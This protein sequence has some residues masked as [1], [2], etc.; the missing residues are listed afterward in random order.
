MSL[1]LEITH[2]SPIGEILR[3][4]V[5]LSGDWSYL[6]SGRPF[7]PAATI[8]K[9]ELPE[10]LLHQAA[11]L[12]MAFDYAARFRIAKALGRSVKSAVLKN[13]V[14]DQAVQVTETDSF[15][16]L[17]ADQV[18]GIL[19]DAKEDVHD[20]LRGKAPLEKMLK[21]ACVLALFEGVAR[22]GR[23]FFSNDETIPLAIVIPAGMIEELERLL[24]LFEQAFMPLVHPDSVVVFNPGYAAPAPIGGSDADLYLDGTLY[25]FKVVSNFKAWAIEKEQILGYYYL[26]RLAK[27]DKAGVLNTLGDRP[28]TR[29]AFYQ[30]RLGEVV[31]HDVQGDE[32]FAQGYLEL[33]EVL[34]KK[35]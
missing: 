30:A 33:E 11:T 6:S 16:T 8:L 3:K 25:D 14:A 26:D 19:Y 27:E 17:Q 10:N 18:R 28:I 23:F 29:L 32:P 31:Y 2:H 13:L 20:Y 1:T 15:Y 22:S 9:L 5:E 12:G 21:A 35:D 7:V 24:T 34:T 4:N